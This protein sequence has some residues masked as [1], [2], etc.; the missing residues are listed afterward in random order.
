MP[1]QLASPDLDLRSFDPPVA[2]RGGLIF[3]LIRSLPRHTAIAIA[4]RYRIR[5]NSSPFTQSLVLRAVPCA[6]HRYLPT[7]HYTDAQLFTY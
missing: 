3:D 4:S 7:H 6:H 2:N 1:Q 5:T